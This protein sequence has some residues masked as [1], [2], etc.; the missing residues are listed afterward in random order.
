[1]RTTDR[2]D[3]SLSVCGRAFAA[4]LF[5]AAGCFNEPEPAY[6]SVPAENRVYL[7]ERGLGDLSG[8]GGALA[9]LCYS[10]NE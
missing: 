9:A 4:A 3:S 7:K 6:R 1:M 5:A 2:A 10:F 8:A